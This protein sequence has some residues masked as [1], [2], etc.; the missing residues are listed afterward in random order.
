MQ[1]V[2]FAYVLRYLYLYLFISQR[3][4]LKFYTGIQNWMLVIIFGSNSG[5]GDDFE[6]SDTK[7]IILRRFLAKRLLELATPKIPGDQ[8][9]CQRVC[10]TLIRKVTNFQLLTPNSF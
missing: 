1:K 2:N 7:T 6:Q 3:I 8:H 5:F 4:K 10:Y 9:L